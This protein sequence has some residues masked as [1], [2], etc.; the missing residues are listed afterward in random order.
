MQ[1]S[2]E[3]TVEIRKYLAEIEELKLTIDAMLAK[4]KKLQDRIKKLEELLKKAE[5]DARE[6]DAKHQVC[7]VETTL[8]T[9]LL[10]NT[11][12]TFLLNTPTNILLT[13]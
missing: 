8:F 5:D 4:E 6:K 9:A 7:G 2:T 11:H 1:E 3:H 10:L 13:A 12:E